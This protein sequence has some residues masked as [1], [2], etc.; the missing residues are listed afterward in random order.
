MA[1]LALSVLGKGS[2]ESGPESSK[3]EKFDML[4]V[5]AGDLAQALGVEN[6]NKAQLKEALRAIRA[7]LKASE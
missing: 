1:G 7:A 4:D 5:P 2:E 3:E 6:A